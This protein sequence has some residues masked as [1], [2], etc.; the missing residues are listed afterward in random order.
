M[1]QTTLLFCIILLDMNMPTYIFYP[2][3]GDFAGGDDGFP[4]SDH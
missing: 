1:V 4:L 2:F 3:D